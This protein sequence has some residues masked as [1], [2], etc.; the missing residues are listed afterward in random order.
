MIKHNELAVRL[1]NHLYKDTNAIEEEI[2]NPIIIEESQHTASS[3]IDAV[4]SSNKFQLKLTSIAIL[5]MIINI[6][7]FGYATELLLGVTWP[8]LGIVAV[9][10]SVNFI[11]NKILNIFST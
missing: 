4:S 11:L 6:M 9:G 1:N 8:F 10:Y 2:N 7:C 5:D 3:S